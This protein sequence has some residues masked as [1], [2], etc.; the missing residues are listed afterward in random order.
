M[1]AGILHGALPLAKGIIFRRTDDP[2]TG[3]FRA[4]VVTVNVIYAYENIR[5]ARLLTLDGDDR[6]LTKS[7]L[8]AVLPN[9]KSLLESKRLAEPFGGC[10]Y[11][12]IGKFGDDHAR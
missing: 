9:L 10:I 4:L 5:G 6:G 11:I 8:E 7:E 3:L 1:S 2:R 12:F